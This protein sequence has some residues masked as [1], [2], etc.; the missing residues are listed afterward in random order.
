MRPAAILFLSL[1]L[2]VVASFSVL[3]AEET[4]VEF[5]P[6]VAKWLKTELSFK[7]KGYSL[8]T[9]VAICKQLS[10]AD[11]RF[12]EGTKASGMPRLWYTAHAYSLEIVL[13]D[14]LKTTE[15]SWKVDG[16]RII[17]GKKQY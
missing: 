12:E 11:L 5:P 15:F 7:S 4:A 9:V 13:N 16:E 6:K 1:L 2:F 8:D 14:I 10:G 17:V 3:S